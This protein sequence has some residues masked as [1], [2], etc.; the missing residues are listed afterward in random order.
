MA[1]PKLS[2]SD[3]VVFNMINE[4][5][6]ERLKREGKIVLPQKKVDI[7]KDRRWNEKALTSAV[8]KGLENGDSVKKVAKN[9]FPE[10]M[11]K[12]DFTGKT[13]KQ[14]YDKGGIIDK[15]RQSAIRN[16]RTM[17]TSAENSGRLDSMKELADQGVVMKKVWESTPDDRTR[18][19][20]VDIDGEEQDI[21]TVFS[22][23]CMFPGDGKGPAEEVWMCRCAMH[24]HII[25]FKNSKGEVSKVNYERDRTLHDE[26]MEEEKARRG[27][28]KTAKPDLLGKTGSVYTK[29]QQATLLSIIENNDS[30][31]KDVYL[32]YVDQ[33]KEINTDIKAGHNAYFSLDDGQVHLTPNNVASATFREDQNAFHTHFHE[34]GHNID[35]L[36]GDRKGWGDCF[37]VKWRDAQGR[38]FEEIITSEWDARFNF[39]SERAMWK[40]FEGNLDISKG[41]MGGEGWVRSGL[42]DWRRA[43]DMSMSDPKFQKVYEEY[44]ALSTD[45]EYRN[46]VKKYI[47]IFNNGSYNLSEFEMKHDIDNFCSH[48]KNMYSLK[49]RGDLSDMFERFSVQHGGPAYP[50]GIGHGAEYAKGE[51]NLALETFA[52]MFSAEISQN[53]SLEVIKQFLPQS[54]NAFKEMLGGL[55]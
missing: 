1:K 11:S 50:F 39:S 21:D 24:T 30:L 55:L 13:Q 41:G 5:A 19:S 16:A 23:G 4:K 40:N 26:Q 18:P 12:T 52:E 29:E 31:S 25:G 45:N 49:E 43:N 36:A 20:H 35:W 34:Y 27:A 8:L 33:F 28:E 46:F 51:Y 38:S 53:E 9:I 42:H 10:I 15:N 6:V 14:I 2:G 22:N 48:M 44:K 7:P 3:A 32:K 47:D 17:M 37:S 54:Y